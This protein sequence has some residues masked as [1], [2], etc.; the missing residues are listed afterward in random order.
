M[1]DTRSSGGPIA[2]G[3]TR[4]VD[5]SR[6]FGGGDAA[7]VVINLTV[8]TPTGGGYLTAF[9]AGT[10]RPVASS[11]NFDH[12]QTRANSV[13]VA[14]GQGG[15][16]NQL[17]IF[18]AVVANGRAQV[19]VDV[20]G[21]YG[22]GGGA[23]AGSVY[24][25]LPAPK[26]LF[27]TRTGI[28]GLT[29]KYP[30]NTGVVTIDYG[31]PAVNKTIT[32]AVM[33]ITVTG[34]RGLGNLTLWNGAGTPPVVST[35]NFLAGQTV[36]NLAVVPVRC[37]TDACKTV[38]FSIRNNLSPYTQV[39]GD[40]SGVYTDP[41]AGGLVYRP[42]APTRVTDTRQRT[43]YGPLGSGAR[44]TTDV[45]RFVSADTRALN[46]NLT[47]VLP[48]SSTYLT[49]YPAGTAQPVV[50][51]LNLARGNVA[52]NAA[53]VRVGPDRR[54]TTANSSGL[55]G[56]VIDLQGSFVADPTT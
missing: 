51:N 41:A 17:A 13:T 9:P 4:V 15:V 56:V 29:T 55:I 46:I 31:T 43:P 21:W 48:A 24:M 45:S 34:T 53:Q 19:V 50:S 49:V 12:N 5:L 35:L 3:T 25:P 20:L 47:G 54:F 7:A 26:R 23:A 10:A 27:D 36:A 39:I 18:A 22:K 40:I 37:S 44:G 33:N 32:A 16:R 52:A 8:T 6:A 14:V 42:L 30:K 2:N 11:L 28:G 1:L 38:T